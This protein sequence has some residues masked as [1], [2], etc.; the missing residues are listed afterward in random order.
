MALIA[1]HVEVDAQPAGDAVITI[2]NQERTPLLSDNLKEET[3][4]MVGQKTVVAQ[5]PVEGGGHAILVTKQVQVSGDY[6]ALPN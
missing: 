4:I 2:E 5:V 6:G 3:G 1:N